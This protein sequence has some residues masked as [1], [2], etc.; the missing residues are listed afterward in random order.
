VFKL[1]PGEFPNDAGSAAG[2]VGAAGGLGGFFPPLVMGVVKDVT[3]T[4]TLGFVGLLTATAACLGLVVWLLRTAPP[5]MIRGHPHEEVDLMRDDSVVSPS[6]DRG[7]PGY[8][9]PAE[10]ATESDMADEVIRSGD[11]LFAV[12]ADMHVVSWNQGAERL[13]GIP[14]VHAVGRPCW[15]VLHAVDED[16]AVVCH[17]GCSGARLA[18]EGWPV[19]C[20]RLS[21]RTKD[22]RRLVFVS[23]I[24]VKLPGQKPLVLELLRDGVETVDNGDDA[25]GAE[26]TP[27]QH[28]VLRLL[29]DGVPAKLIA[30]R[31]G[32]A[33]VTVRN[34]IRAILSEL[35]CHSQLEAVA[36][37]RRRGLVP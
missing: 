16:G 20:R 31:L 13:T 34:H 12:D 36:E 6:P 1:V 5:A 9:A 33:E 35:H 18:R 8:E 29:A 3:G 15:D 4:Y 24:S 26:L 25:L 30:G 10:P 7:R 14:A 32:I 28:E 19:P 17:P 22:G 23:T 11:A 27:R 21:I 2:I 37:A